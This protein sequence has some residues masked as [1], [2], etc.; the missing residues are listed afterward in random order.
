MSFQ[1]TTGNRIKACRK[2]F[3][4]APFAKAL[5]TFLALCSIMSPLLFPPNLRLEVER[6]QAGK[7]G[8][9]DGLS[10]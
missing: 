8:P 4:T 7:P 3:V 10:L 5:D 1:F 9:E 2:A 6:A